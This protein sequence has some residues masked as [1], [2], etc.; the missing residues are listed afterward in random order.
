MPR[1]FI[2]NSIAIDDELR[3]RVAN[4]AK[5][6]G[7]SFSSWVRLQLIKALDEKSA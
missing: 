3:D 2:S 1:K 7:K 6:E 5:A 4:I